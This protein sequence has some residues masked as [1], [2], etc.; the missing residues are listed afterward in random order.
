MFEQVSK[1]LSEF[2]Y[3]GGIIGLLA[4][5]F[6]MQPV[7]LMTSTFTE[8]ILL[9][10]E[11]RFF[12]KVINFCLQT[13][14]ISLFF[15]TLLIYSYKWH[16]KYYLFI[17]FFMLGVILVGMVLVFLIA[18][19]EK[20]KIY[21]RSIVLSTSPTIRTLSVIFYMLFLFSYISVLPYYVGSHTAALLVGDLNKTE[22]RTL[23]FAALILVILFSGLLVAG[24]KFMIGIMDANRY[25]LYGRALFIQEQETLNKWFIYHPT[26]KVH[27]ILG[28]TPNPSESTVNRFIETT[29]LLNEKIYVYKA[30]RE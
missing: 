10:K 2:G 14:Y 12:V 24:L 25:N 3:T 6:K 19:F 17:S 1:F 13:I 20:V 15:S 22:Q 29:V 30:E 7:T 28:D 9:S 8:K 21:V 23:L 11:K 4:A 5:F 18:S 27:F 26:N 16:Y